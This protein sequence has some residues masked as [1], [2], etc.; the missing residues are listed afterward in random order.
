MFESLTIKFLNSV[1]F[2]SRT[3]DRITFFSYLPTCWQKKTT[4][5]TCR[6]NWY[7]YLSQKSLRTC[8]EARAHWIEKMLWRI[9][10]LQFLSCIENQ[11]RKCKGSILVW[12]PWCRLRGQERQSRES[13][14]TEYKY[15]EEAHT[16]FTLVGTR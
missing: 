2:K 14:M 12:N 16:P 9:V 5:Q 4:L 11:R 3:K 8:P 10:V 6:K 15:N 7:V 1:I 13:S